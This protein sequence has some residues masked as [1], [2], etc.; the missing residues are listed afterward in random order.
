[1]TD[2][3]QAGGKGKEERGYQP[4]C[5]VSSL[6]ANGLIISLDKSGIFQP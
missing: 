2:D 3:S 4:S 1:M 5:C 6:E